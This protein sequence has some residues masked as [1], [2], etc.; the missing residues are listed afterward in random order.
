MR[1]SLILYFTI[2]ILLSACSSNAI[3]FDVE[4][5][6]I[7]SCNSKGIRTLY[8]EGKSTNESYTI[9]WV[10]TLANAPTAIKLG[11]VEDGYVIEK[12][13]KSEK[14]LKREFKLSPSSSYIIQRAQ[15]D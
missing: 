11:D 14:V 8:I 15:G 6:S 13:W 3:S 4:K 9:S 7:V 10:D 1:Q 12:G 2:L 5:Q